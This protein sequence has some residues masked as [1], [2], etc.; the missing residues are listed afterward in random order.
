MFITTKTVTTKPNCTALSNDKFHVLGEM[1]PDTR[2]KMLKSKLYM[3][4]LKTSAGQ[5]KRKTKIEDGLMTFRS[6]I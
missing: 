2:V 1:S 4:S 3:L 5:Q 6:C